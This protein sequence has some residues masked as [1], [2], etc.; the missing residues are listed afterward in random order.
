[1]EDVKKIVVAYLT[2]QIEIFEQLKMLN[3]LSEVK[4]KEQANEMRCLMSQMY[5]YADEN[6]FK[7]ILFSEPQLQA[8]VLMVKLSI[9]VWKEE[10][11]TAKIVDS[12]RFVERVII[13]VLNG[14]FNP[15]L[16]DAIIYV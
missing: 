3:I 7:K 8:F 15:E 14:V 5:P 11:P 10:N 16:K 1:M 12:A 6:K 4:K 9:E 2:K 13:S